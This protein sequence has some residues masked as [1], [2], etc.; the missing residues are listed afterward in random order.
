[1]L[2]LNAVLA[3]R[4]RHTSQILLKAG[5]MVKCSTKVNIRIAIK[6]Y[7]P[8][9]PLYTKLYIYCKRTRYFWGRLFFH[10]MLY[11]ISIF[12]RRFLKKTL[13]PL[14]LV[15]YEMIT[16]NSYPARARGIIVKCSL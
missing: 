10:F 11:Q 3:A 13:I 8:L 1:M 15:E 4:Y 2:L 5:A 12:W 16:T 9:Y 7:E 14:A 6:V